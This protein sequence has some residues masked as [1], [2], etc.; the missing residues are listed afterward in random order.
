M[1]PG[2][3]TPAR[4]ECGQEEEETSQHLLPGADSPC[5][6]D[7]GSGS[8]AVTLPRALLL[9]PGAA[10]LRA[11][12]FTAE[13]RDV[14]VVPLPGFHFELLGPQSGAAR[15][16]PRAVPTQAER[17]GPWLRWV[18]GGARSRPLLPLSLASA[19]C[20]A[21]WSPGQTGQGPLLPPDPSFLAL[22]VWGSVARPYAQDPCLPGRRVLM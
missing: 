1:T 3:G 15:N 22:G 4:R 20:G 9:R 2:P 18:D 8:L 5:P 12:R 21:P 7:S 10:G 11:P 6:A 16:P 19:P 13:R 14:A 17:S